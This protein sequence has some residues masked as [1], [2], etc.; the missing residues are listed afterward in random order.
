VGAGAEKPL[1]WLAN[2]VAAVHATDLYT[3]HSG[4]PWGSDFLAD[5]GAYA[6]IEF[7]RDHLQVEVM[8]GTALAF[9]DDT[10]DFAYSLSSIE[11]FGG[12]EAAARAMREIHRVLRPG[13]VACIATELVLSEA[14]HPEMFTI[15]ELRRHV[16]EASALQLVE[17]GIDLRIS[18]SLLEHPYDIGRE[19]HLAHS[20][21]I[22]MT[23][24]GTTLWTSIIMFLRKPLG[25]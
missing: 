11:H 14:P 13:G 20:P 15:E 3:D 1:F 19:T 7:S 4:Y 24:D 9:A 23:A 12:H 6:P 22:V 10:F 21:H 25:G 2:R 17:D 16:I 18:S 8:S 5:P